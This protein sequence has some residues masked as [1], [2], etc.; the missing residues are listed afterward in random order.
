[1]TWAWNTTTTTTTGTA[2][3]SWTVMLQP[4]INYDQPWLRG[5]GEPVFSTCTD[6]AISPEVCFDVNGYY[7]ELGVHWKA[8]KRELLFAYRDKDGPND[9]RLTYI[10]KQLLDS[11][12]RRTYDRAP[13]GSLYFDRYVQE[14]V[15]RMIKLRMAAQGMDTGRADQF[16]QVASMFGMEIDDVTESPEVVDKNPSES[17]DEIAPSEATPSPFRYSYY[18]WRS[19][20]EDTDRL[21]L[22]QSLLIQA[23][24]AT[25]QKVHLAVG[26]HGRMAHP[27]LLFQVGYRTV[28]FLHEQGEPTLELA[29]AVAD[30][31]QRDQRKSLTR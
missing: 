12:I 25:Q 4:Q 22:W 5:Q 3:S 24:R 26:Y 13:L 18:L 20:C 30:Q 8:S 10:F 15:S 6:L 29:T 21:A 28:V 1:V 23:F 17:H 31:Y 9:E 16:S 19:G 11:A 27:W 7:R 14:R 2:S